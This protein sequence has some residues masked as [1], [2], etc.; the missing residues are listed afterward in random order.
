LCKL[1]PSVAIIIGLYLNLLRQERTIRNRDSLVG[2]FIV[3]LSKCVC[4]LDQLSIGPLS[5]MAEV[6]GQVTIS[7]VGS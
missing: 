6:P 5:I 7:V 1:N 3:N 4:F 2:S